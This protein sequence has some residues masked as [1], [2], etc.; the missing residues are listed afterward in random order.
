V[1]TADRRLVTFRGISKLPRTIEASE[2]SR[3]RFIVLFFGAHQAALEVF[4][5]ITLLS[6]RLK[7][8]DPPSR[9]LTTALWYACGMPLRFP[10]S[11]VG[12]AQFPLDLLANL[13]MFR[14]YCCIGPSVGICYFRAQLW[15]LSKCC[16]PPVG[17]LEMGSFLGCASAG[18]PWESFPGLSESLPSQASAAVSG[19][20]PFDC[21]TRSRVP[22]LGGGENLSTCRGMVR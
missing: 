12:M 14:R 8:S 6:E 9:I 11:G 10:A 1:D 13:A 4:T 2:R 15:T 16:P 7:Q 21:T 22:S 19:E 5:P 3:R 17:S 20:L 18:T